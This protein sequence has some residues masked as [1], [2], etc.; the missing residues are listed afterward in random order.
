MSDSNHNLPMARSW[1]DIPQEV[2]PR[3]MSRSGRRRYVWSLTKIVGGGAIVLALAVATVAVVDLM[4]NKPREVARAAQAAPLRECKLTTDGVLDRAWL[5]QTLALPKGVTLME[6]DL[7]A[8]QAR[9]LAHRQV[10]TAVLA[11]VFP[12]TLT[13][14]LTERVPVA[15]VQARLGQE[16]PQA[17]LVARDGV[18]FPGSGYTAEECATLPWLDGLRLVRTGDTFAPI[19]GMDWVAEL[20]SKAKYEAEHLY[21][22]FQVVSLARLTS[23][24]ELEVRTPEITQVIFTV[25][26]DF[27]RQLAKL[28][29]I[30]DALRPQP[31]APLP[32]LDLSHGREVPVTFGAAP[33]PAAKTTPATTAGT[34]PTRP[35]TF[36][37]NRL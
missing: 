6:L 2:K 15:R 11:K 27:F 31:E 19:E 4:E 23:D 18:A 37:I 1:R 12:S 8:L 35:T 13:V 22:T 29:S 7:G 30:R 25:H 5:V 24:G 36:T 28:D 34:A 16:A 32:R 9:L 14:T 33:V 3:A 10:R 20:L 26:D 17:Y 21:R